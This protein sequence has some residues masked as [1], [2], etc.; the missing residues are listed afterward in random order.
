M[1]TLRLARALTI[2]VG[3]RAPDDLARITGHGL[4]T[5]S[6]RNRQK[7]DT[8]AVDDGPLDPETRVSGRALLNS[9][10]ARKG[11][12]LLTGGETR[13]SGHETSL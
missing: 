11:A 6:A 7:S 13:V 2:A 3:V 8:F 5:I 10:V 9:G 12:L 4:G 1:F